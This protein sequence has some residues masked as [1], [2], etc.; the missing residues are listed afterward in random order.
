MTMSI[1][2]RR[3]PSGRRSAASRHGVSAMFME[4]PRSY[5][6]KSRFS[7]RILAL[8]GTVTELR[9]A[10][11]SSYCSGKCEPDD[12]LIGRGSVLSSREQLPAALPHVGDSGERKFILGGASGYRWPGF[13]CGTRGLRR[14]VRNTSSRY[15]FQATSRRGLPPERQAP[16]G[17]FAWCSGSSIFF[18]ECAFS[19]PSK[20]LKPRSSSAKL[21]T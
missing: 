17:R 18:D 21:A 16:I 2:A 15:R 13:L 19:K 1:Q 12:D 10:P 11:T 4:S 20:S 5:A 7:R 3:G 14:P 6:L 8:G 9:G